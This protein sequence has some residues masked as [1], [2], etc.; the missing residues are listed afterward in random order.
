MS[1][2]A[3][4]QTSTGSVWLCTIRLKSI[5]EIQTSQHLPYGERLSGTDTHDQRWE[6]TVYAE[7]ASDTRAR[8][9]AIWTQAVYKTHNFQLQEPGGLAY[10]ATT[11]AGGGSWAEHRC[12]SSSLNPALL[13]NRPA[14]GDQ[15]ITN[16]CVDVYLTGRLE[17]NRKN[18][19]LFSSIRQL[20]R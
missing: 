5:L 17:K 12:S 2:E 10:I 6:E 13:H 3:D 7:V 1:P 16:C 11:C 18:K 15:H 14:R 4:R 20:L 9:A 19:D 8:Q